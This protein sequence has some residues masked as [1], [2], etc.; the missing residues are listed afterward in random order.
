MGKNSSQS[1][2]CTGFL[3]GMVLLH[4]NLDVLKAFSFV[5]MDF[6]KR[7]FQIYPQY[8][9]TALSENVIGK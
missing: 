9:F 2:G 8:G 3:L 4:F 6:F 7:T 5:Y 1:L